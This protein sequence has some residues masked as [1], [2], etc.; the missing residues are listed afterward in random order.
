MFKKIN[1]LLGSFLENNKI[2]TERKNIE[3]A[4][5]E[6]INKETAKN[7]TVVGFENGTLLVKAKNPTWRMELT[8]KTEEIKKKLTNKQ[9]VK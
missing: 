5:D 1:S 3:K 6:N 2:T 9:K 8:L 4:W 7:T